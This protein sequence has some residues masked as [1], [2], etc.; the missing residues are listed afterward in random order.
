MARRWGHLA[1]AV[2]AALVVGLPCAPARAGSADTAALQVALRSFGVFSGSVDGVA[3]PATASA[4]RTFQARHGLTPDGVAGPS[5]RSAFGGRGQPAWGT[6]TIGS[7]AR[8]WDVAALQYALAAHGFPCG[9]LD[10]G[11]GGHVQAALL[12]FQRFA[13]LPLAG[14]AGPATRA[15]LAR[16]APPAPLG[17]LRPVAAPVGDRWGARGAAWHPGLDFPAPTGAPVHAA[18]SGTVVVAGFAADG[19]G[20]RVVIA[21]GA[22]EQTLYAH[23]SAVLVR[24]GAAVGGGALI[25]R[26]GA[27]GY[28]TGPHLHFELIVRGAKIDPAPYL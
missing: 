11:F 15:A 28:A 10:G 9:P 22:G 27:T 18:R 25:G 14:V 13:G 20:N 23:L 6:R 1:A 21:H 12:Q 7:G 3:G 24:A 19:Y 16:S 4:V 8:G 2:T 17:I 26:V 5:T